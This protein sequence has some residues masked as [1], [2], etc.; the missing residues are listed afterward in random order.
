[1]AIDSEPERV[2]QPAD[3]QPP[4]QPVLEPLRVLLGTWRGEGRGIYPTIESF[5][6]LEEVR[7]WHV[8]KPFLGYEQRT[9]SPETRLPM[10][11]ESGYWRVLL[12][13]GD[14]AEGARDAASLE[15]V[16][17]HPTGLAE[18]LVGEIDGTRITLATATVARTPTAKEVS[19]VERRF[20]LEDEDTLAYEV[21]MAA[22]GQPLQLHLAAT[23]HRVDEAG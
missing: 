6:Y 13:A 16:L 23:L 21:H 17:A 1:M 5:R 12:G 4:L 22:V 10:H 9:R 14:A 20:V 15:V 11:T 19:A 18:V 8:G 2:A 7:F 3:P